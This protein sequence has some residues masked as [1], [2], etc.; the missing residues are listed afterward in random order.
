MIKYSISPFLCG[1]S[2][3]KVSPDIEF[4]GKPQKKFFS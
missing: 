1:I 2:K 3:K 4:L